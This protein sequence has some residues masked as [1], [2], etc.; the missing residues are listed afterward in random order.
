MN[1]ITDL[2]LS[3][4]DKKSKANEKGV[5]LCNYMDVYS[6]SFISE[7]LRIVQDV[8][9]NHLPAGVEVRVFGSRAQGS[10]R[11]ATWTWRSKAKRKSTA[12]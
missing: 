1:E 9:R 5:Q 10:A 8:L 6:N 11:D 2:T 4:V 3:S 7:N 12:R